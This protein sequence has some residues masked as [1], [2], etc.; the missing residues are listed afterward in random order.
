MPVTM[1]CPTRGRGLRVPR[2]KIG[3]EVRCPSCQSP[4]VLSQP[5]PPSPPSPPPQRRTTP[6][7]PLQRRTPET[8]MLVICPHCGVTVSLEPNA[9]TE[10]ASCPTCGGNFQLPGPGA[11]PPG[12]QVEPSWAELA[13]Q[14]AKV[15][16]PG[17][18]ERD[19]KPGQRRPQR[20]PAEYLAIGLPLLVVALVLVG[21]VAFVAPERG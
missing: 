2:K 1:K 16:V 11:A 17:N 21:A 5:V 8:A 9:M 15:P 7:P 13:P 20:I 14:E 3:Q 4:F 18:E 10:A 19:W 6:P 12:P